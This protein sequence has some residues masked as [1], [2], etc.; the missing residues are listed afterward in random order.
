MSENNKQ[1]FYLGLAVGVA[2]ISTL[3]FFTMLLSGG[4]GGSFNL[5]L[6]SLFKTSPRKFEAC[7]ADNS[8]TSK[9]DSDTQEGGG[10]GVD[11][12]PATFV[13]GYLISGA[14]PY[15][16][17]KPVIDEVLAGQTP[18]DEVLKNRDTG[19]ITKVNVPGLKDGEPFRGTK[20]GKILI[21]EYS[22]YECPFCLRFEPTV[23]QI[24][25][26]YGDKVTFVYR[27]FPLSIHA[28]ARPAAIAAE[29]ANKQGK[30]WEMHDKLFE[31]NQSQSLN[32]DSYMKAASELKLK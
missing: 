9:I 32:K 6:G 8:V 3:G 16:L 11:G 18:A 7:L 14:Q 26:D 17:I 10:L 23:K 31:L 12:T 27:N 24:L 20:D 30:F 22:D 15:A 5:N 4:S 19:E 28:Q 2:V 29:C 13:G 1:Q 21:A 25:A